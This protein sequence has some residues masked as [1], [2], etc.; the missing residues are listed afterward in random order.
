MKLLVVLSVCL[1]LYLNLNYALGQDEEAETTTTQAT[2]TTVNSTAKV[3]K[4]VNWTE[5]EEKW[6][7][8]LE[9][10]VVYAKWKKLDENLKNGMY[11]LKR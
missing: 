9:D 4:K 8:V 10:D 7:E 5:V 11:R 3:S 6:N 2:T 1:C